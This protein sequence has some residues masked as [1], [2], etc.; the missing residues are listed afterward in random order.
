MSPALKKAVD[1]LCLVAQRNS[2]L[3]SA[4]LP[5]EDVDEGV[6]LVFLQPTVGAIA[7][8]PVRVEEARSSTSPACTYAVHL[9]GKNGS[10]E[11]ATIVTN[12]TAAFYLA[13]AQKAEEVGA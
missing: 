4:V 7:H 3:A 12:A 6:V 11:D 10:G 9:D 1:R 2:F 8:G 13:L 5:R